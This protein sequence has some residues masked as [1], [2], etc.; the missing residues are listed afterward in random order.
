M[1]TVCSLTARRTLLHLRH[2]TVLAL[3]SSADDTC[4]A[5][6]TSSGQI[7]SNV[8]LKQNHVY[9]LSTRLFSK[10]SLKLF[11]RHEPFGGIHPYRAVQAHQQNMVP[12]SSP[13]AHLRW[14]LKRIG[15]PI[16]VQRALKD[17]CISA[18]D[19]DGIAFTRGPG[20]YLFGVFVL[21]TTFMIQE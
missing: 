17:A 10:S 19:V 1:T 5:V 12:S 3:E 15:Q 14:S 2:F 6:V 7:L 16:A 8:V 13:R 9:V 21:P 11:F 20:Q 18:T 4:A